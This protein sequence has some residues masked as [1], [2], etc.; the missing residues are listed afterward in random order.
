MAATVEVTTKPIASVISLRWIISARDDLVWFIGSVISSYLLLFLYV[1]GI[2]PLVPMAVAWAILIDAPHVFGTFSRTYFDRTERRN[3]GRL[4][5]GSLLFFAVG[6]L[7][8]LAGA[9]FVFFFVAA[10]WAYYHLVKQHYGFMVLY[11]KKNGDL[12]RVDNL[13]DRTLLLFAFNYPF[14]EFI[15]RDPEAMARVPAV[16]HGGV[17]GL[18]TILFVATIVV[19][20]VWLAR[21]IQRTLSGESLN[22]PKYLLLAAAIPMH[23]IV[24]LT[25]MPHKPIAIVAILT[26]YHNF[27][28]HRLIWFH[29]KKYNAPAL[30]GS[31]PTVK[32][33]SHM[34]PAAQAKYGAASLISRRLI[35]YVAFGILFGVIYQGPR[36]FLGYLSFQRAT[37]GA[38]EQP[39]VMQLGISFLWGYAFI[40]YYLDSKIWRVRRDPSVGKALNM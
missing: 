9:A 14:V 33:G 29:N 37:A 12:A 34:D 24:L 32:E 4:L 8:V 26:I 23:W 39:F 2:L 16:L 5:W 22:V 10:L 19:G 28:Y 36:Q 40:H 17:G 18:S 20:V 31:S 38:V 35:Y 7:L 30:R 21:Q 13:L 1:K 3:R 25:P 11:K 27:Q 15:A 6:P